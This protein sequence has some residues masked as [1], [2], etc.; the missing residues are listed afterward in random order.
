MRKIVDTINWVYD[1]LMSLGVSIIVEKRALSKIISKSGKNKHCKGITQWKGKWKV[2]GHVNKDYYR[3]F[4]QYIGE[5]VNIVPDDICHNVIEPILNP[6]RF[7]SA[8][9]DKCLFDKMLWSSFHTY[10]TPKTYIRNIGGAYFDIN[11]NQIA[12]VEDCIKT[13][14]TS[15]NKLIIKKSIDSSSGKGIL[16]FTRDIMGLF[17]DS[18]GNLLTE[19]FLAQTLKKD[20]VIQEVM[21][22][23]PYMDQFCKTS[24]NTI[25][26][27]VYRSIKTNK[28]ITINSTLRIGKEGSLVDNAHAGGRLIGISRNGTLGKYCCDQFGVKNTI[29]N[30]INFE[31][32]N[33]TIPN[34]EQVKSFA[35]RV[36]SALPH[37]RLIAL[38]IMLDSNNQPI[39]LE[40]NIRGFGIWAFQFTSG[41]GFGEYTD[42]IIEYCT[43]HKKDATRILV[44]F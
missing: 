2:L 28:P 12:S 44:M 10:V 6:K 24:V 9:E 15:V 17:K 43:K 1:K 38:D 33:Y 18:S 7:I 35:E 25:R 21:T 4:S 14:S 40:Y 23:S 13:I 26:V 36:A 30:G 19:Q 41:T 37:Q 29:F 16:F 42:E 22:Q 5:D 27:A 11:Y 20:F 32:E 3:I 39:L 8:Y 31:S 34:Y